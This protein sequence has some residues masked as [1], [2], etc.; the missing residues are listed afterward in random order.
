MEWG[1]WTQSLGGGTGTREA[2][3]FPASVTRPRAM[4]LTDGV[5]EGEAGSGC[6]EESRGEADDAEFAASSWASWG[7]LK[8]GAESRAKRR[9]WVGHAGKRERERVS[10]GKGIQ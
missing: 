4:S 2:P 7:S 9:G 3:G 5:G 8:P 1:L 6:G 10:W